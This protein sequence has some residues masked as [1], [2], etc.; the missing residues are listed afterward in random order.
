MFLQTFRY[1]NNMFRILIIYID[2]RYAIK[3]M[4]TFNFLQVNN[5]SGINLIVIIVMQ[6][7]SFSL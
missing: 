6:G 4:T 7:S 3:L 1:N 2:F 5:K